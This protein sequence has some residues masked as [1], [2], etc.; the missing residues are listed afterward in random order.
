MQQDRLNFETHESFI[1]WF[2]VYIVFAVVAMNAVLFILSLNSKGFNYLEH[3]QR[4]TGYVVVTALPYILVDLIYAL[5][6]SRTTLPKIALKVA[7]STGL[8]LV[9]L[10]AITEIKPLYNE[11]YPFLVYALG[12]FACIMLALDV[13]RHATQVLPGLNNRVLVVGNDR[14]ADDM[15]RLINAAGDRFQLAGSV[16]LPQAG[17]NQACQEVASLFETAKRLKANKVVISLAER[18]GVFP[19]QEMLNCKLSGIEVLDAPS[20]YERITGKLL[21][22]NISPSWFIFSSGF[23]VTALLKL[24]KRLMDLC[25]SVFGLMLFAPMA[26]LVMLAIRLDSPGP[27]FFRQE[28]VGQGDVPFVLFKFRTN[29]PGRGRNHRRGLGHHGRPADHSV[30]TVFCA[31]S[32]ID[33]IPQLIN[34][35]QRRDEPYRSPAGTPGVR[36]QAQ[37]KSSPITPSAIS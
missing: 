12:L 35:V 10:Q 24:V 36:A 21:I 16:S 1:K 7:L 22:E 28:R 26:P 31:K 37:G 9:L 15:H 23:R 32:R 33:E 18:R 13:W 5:M 30:G 4:L 2:I 8:S 29:A 6:R 25:C 20:M 34:V 14:L 27:I 17:A 3:H 19:L 11:E